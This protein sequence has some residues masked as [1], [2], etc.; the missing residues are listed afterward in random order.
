MQEKKKIKDSFLTSTD[1]EINRVGLSKDD[2]KASFL[3]NL[4]YGIGRIPAVATRNDLYTA[5]AL[6]IRDRVFRKFVRTTEKFA[7]QDARAVAYLSAEYLPGPHLANNLLNLNIMQQAR[8]AL[9]ELDIQLDTLFEQEEEPGLGNGGLGRLAS[10]YMDSLA[11]LGVPAIAYGIR[12]EFGIFD[13]MIQDGWQVELTDK[14][15]HLGNPWEVIR[16]E[17]AYEVKFGGRTEHSIDHQGRFQVQWIPNAVVKGIAYDTPILGYQSNG[18]VLRLWRAEA[19]ESFDFA[20]FNLGD[21]YRAVEAK[22]SSENITKVLYPNDQALSGKELRLKQQ[23]FFVTCSLQ[24]I[25]KLHIL[26][27]RS[28]EKFHEKFTIQ[29]NDTHPAIAV[30]ELM[31]LLVD[32]HQ[33]DWDKAWYITRHTFA[34]TNHT[35][36]PEALEKWSI[37]LFAK[38]L[39]RHLEIIYE[40]NHRFLQ[41]L[42]QHLSYSDE[43]IARVSL[44]YEHGERYIRMAHLATVGSYKVNGVS[45]LHSELLKEQVLHDFADLWPDKFSN[46]TNGVTQ[47]RFLAV[48]N[49]QLAQLI[50][51]HIGK[52]WLT[53]LDQLRKLEELADDSSFQQ[54]WR[55][56]KTSN[57]QALSRIIQERTGIQVNPDSLFD[58]QAK[59]IHEYK[60]QHLNVLH[61]LS[62][63]LRLKKGEV[64]D[65]VPYTFIFAG[66]AAPGYFMAKLIIRLINAVAEVINHDTDIQEQLKV[67]FI[68]DFNVK[69]AQHLYPAAD[70]SEQISVAGMEASGTGNMKFALNGALTIGTL[71]GANVEI[72]QE[73]GE[74][75]FFLFGL[76]AEQV[77]ATKSSGYQPQSI[78]EQNRQ[79]REVL[80]YIVSGALSHVDTQ[81]FRPLYENLLWQDPYLVLADYQAYVEGQEQVRQLWLRPQE[82]TRKA[83][84]NVARMG[85]FSSD[86]SIQDYCKRIWNIEPIRVK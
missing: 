9:E 18:I 49:P 8:Q 6:T 38:V 13:Q 22:M 84:L 56:I 50:S 20:A 2:I 52:E 54:S 78:Y 35:L 79:L 68:P 26:Q 1:L 51:H 73:I 76:T 21:Y 16:P 59:R 11:T 24:D 41:E 55:D 29:L 12:Y 74:D 37:P 43:Q 5:M 67:V 4:F 85:K 14:W 86:R 66:K 62:L 19:I 60:R 64:N 31:R 70:L 40:I 34:Y 53:D 71:D 28:I 33:L 27:G 23:Y 75:N 69:N 39:P 7:E 45:A 48:C 15:L 61:I 65:M 10:C 83:I 17:I 30:A 58:V 77:Q 63:Y 32:E 57:K 42:R 36:L 47:R 44:I 72:R 25:I 80:D 46:V 82:W 3:E 81:L